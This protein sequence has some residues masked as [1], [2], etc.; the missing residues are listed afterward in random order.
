MLYIYSMYLLLYE[1]WGNNKPEWWGYKVFT[2][3]GGAITNQ[4]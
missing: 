4:Y 3:R 2:R 1:W